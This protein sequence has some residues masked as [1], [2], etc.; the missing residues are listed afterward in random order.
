V[1][2]QRGILRDVL[3]IVMPRAPRCIP[4]RLFVPVFALIVSDL[5]LLAHLHVTESQLSNFCNFRDFSVH[6][7]GQADGQTDMYR[8]TRLVILI[9]SIHILWGRKRFFIPVTY[10]P[11]NLVYPFILRVTGIK[12]MNCFDCFDVA[13]IAVRNVSVAEISISFLKTQFFGTCVVFGLFAG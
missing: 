13:K 5:P 4:P 9:K 1:G 8:S 7:D 6:P 12:T 2:Q 11:T 3:P 10:F